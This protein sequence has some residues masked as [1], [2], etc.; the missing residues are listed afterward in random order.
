MIESIMGYFI[1]KSFQ[2]LIAKQIEGFQSMNRAIK[3]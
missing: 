3:Q 1:R 2:N